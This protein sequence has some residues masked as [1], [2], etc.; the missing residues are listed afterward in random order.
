MDTINKNFKT[1]QERI[2]MV[3]K[4]LKLE[5]PKNNFSHPMIDS[6]WPKRRWEMFSH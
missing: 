4:L 5:A 1:D 6:H 2:S 3:K